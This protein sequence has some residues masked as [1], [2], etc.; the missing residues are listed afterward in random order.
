M[1]TLLRKRS[2]VAL[3]AALGLLL[4]VIAANFFLIDRQRQDQESVQHSL[5][6]ELGL[7]R[8]FSMLQDAETGQRGYLLTGSE[9]YLDPYNVAVQNIDSEMAALA[10]MVADNSEQS[11]QLAALRDAAGEKLKELS[12]TIA[13]ARGGDRDAS[14]AR[15]QKGAGHNIMLRPELRISLARGSLWRWS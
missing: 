10:S 14:I 1:P 11:R 5:K 6:V 3:I 8:I 12:K 13:L 4:A 9:A 2:I 7:A 15:V